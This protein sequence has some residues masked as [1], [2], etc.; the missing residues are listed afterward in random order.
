MQKNLPY[1]LLVTLLATL[2][3]ILFQLCVNLSQ[4]SVLHAFVQY[5]YAEFSLQVIRRI[6]TTAAQLMN[7]VVRYLWCI[8][9]V[10][11]LALPFLNIGRMYFTLRL[12]RGAEA[13]PADLLARTGCLLKALWLQILTFLKVL[14]WGIPG[15][16]VMLLGSFALVWGASE[17]V[18]TFIY[19]LGLAL[20]VVLGMR[21]NLHY[22]LAPIFMADVPEKSAWTCLKDSVDMMRRHVL[23]LFSLVLSFFL[24]IFL[25]DIV[26][27]LVASLSYG[28]AMLVNVAANVFITAY[29]NTTVC[30]YYEERLREKQ[31]AEAA[32]AFSELEADGTVV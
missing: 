1:V 7:P 22:M 26:V 19:F 5:Q 32:K 10:L 14:L 29:M 24:W 4:T 30:A 31:Q 20:M 9:P 13:T 23:Q 17:G 3:S 16:A 21:A 12:L 6:L 18:F 25:A 11:Y 2:P 15:F 28:L 27:N 8:V